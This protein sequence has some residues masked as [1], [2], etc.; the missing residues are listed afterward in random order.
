MMR[1]MIRFCP[2]RPIVEM[3]RR[4]QN[5]GENTLESLAFFKHGQTNFGRGYDAGVCLPGGRV[6]VVQNK[7]LDGAG[8]QVGVAT[9]MM[10]AVCPLTLTRTLSP[11]WGA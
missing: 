3:E 7:A 2:F 10:L 5:S 11:G 6:I 8:L 4:Y 1:S 9:L